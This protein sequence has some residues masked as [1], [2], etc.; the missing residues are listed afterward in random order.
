MRREHGNVY[1]EVER[2]KKNN[3]LA[4]V[5]INKVVEGLHFVY[6][7]ILPSKPSVPKRREPTNQPHLFPPFH[8][9]LPLFLPSPFRLFISVYI[10]LYTFYLLFT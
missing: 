5:W 2:D 9:A 8:D 1:G 6:T 3:R 4:F 10:Y 7:F